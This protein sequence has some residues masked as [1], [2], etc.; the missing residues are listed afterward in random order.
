M[1]IFL[2]TKYV[3][4]VADCFIDLYVDIRYF[5]QLEAKKG[6]TVKNKILTD[7]WLMKD[8]S[9]KKWEILK[10]ISQIS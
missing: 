7:K 6:F 4:G 9:R 5:G 2:D 1:K 10:K 3:K 8:K